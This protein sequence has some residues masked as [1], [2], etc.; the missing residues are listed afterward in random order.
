MCIGVGC[1]YASDDHGGAVI[2]FIG[3]GKA[4]GVV[5]SGEQAW[6]IATVCA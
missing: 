2:T 4:T 3:S 5:A 1:S 6:N